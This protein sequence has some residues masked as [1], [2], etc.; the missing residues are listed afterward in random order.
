MTM[1]HRGLKGKPCFTGHEARDFMEVK[2]KKII[3]I[4]EKITK[5]WEEKIASDFQNKKNPNETSWITVQD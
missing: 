1:F 4:V 5:H 2:K 3:K